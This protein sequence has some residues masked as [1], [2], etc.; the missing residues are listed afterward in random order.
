MEILIYPAAYESA[1]FITASLTLIRDIGGTAERTLAP[2]AGVV[3]A[4]NGDNQ[5]NP[6]S[7]YSPVM[8]GLASRGVARALARVTNLPNRVTPYDMLREAGFVVAA[9]RTPFHVYM[10]YISNTPDELPFV[11]PDVTALLTRLE[12]DAR[13][14]ERAAL[15]RV[16]NTLLADAHSVALDSH[17]ALWH[18]NMR[19]R[20]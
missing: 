18:Q 8:L 5:P 15:L 11:T 12:S 16:A 2:L 1:E 13:Q 3:S 7:Q 9:L 4:V 20:H 14:N 10:H 6:M 17:S 19:R